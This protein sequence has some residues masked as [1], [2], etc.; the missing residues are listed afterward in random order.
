MLTADEVLRAQARALIRVMVHY[1]LFRAWG[2]APTLIWRAIEAYGTA[3]CDASDLPTIHRDFYGTALA[4]SSIGLK[5][6][7]SNAPL[8]LALH[9]FAAAAD[10]YRFLQPAWWIAVTVAYLDKKPVPEPSLQGEVLERLETAFEAEI[11]AEEI[12]VPRI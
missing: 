2:G 4:A 6:R 11:T 9:T 7:A 1:K 3:S 8:F 10:E 12:R 5:H